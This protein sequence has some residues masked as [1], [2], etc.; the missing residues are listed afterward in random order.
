MV[1]RIA[2]CV[3]QVPDPDTPASAFR[4][5]ESAKRVIPAPGSPPV[6]NGFDLNATE[7]ALRIKDS[8]GGDEVEITV[9]AIGAGFVMDVVKRPLSMG[10]DHL[11]LVED[12]SLADLDGVATAKMLAAVL[13]RQGPFDL[14]LCGR[15]A[16]DWDN[17]YV[18]LGVAE[19]LGLPC[20][21]LARRVEV[22][23]GSIRVE[24][25][26][27]DGYQVVESA[28]P[29]LVTVSNEAGEPRYPTLRGIMSATRKAPTRIAP[30]ELGLGDGDLASA[31]HLDRLFVP[32]S[33][34]QCE[35]LEGDDDVDSGRRLALRLREENL[36]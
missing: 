34:R 14:L 22:A 24:R 30:D 26:L 20:L 11:V 10:A 4:V 29:A 5:D 31:M 8:L 21:T 9:L 16:S 32:Q 27:T 33:D 17:A 13:E 1:L 6:V 25:A 3:K 36:I 35:F 12:D 23:D 15:Q 18:P 7:A 2:V 19:I 28:L